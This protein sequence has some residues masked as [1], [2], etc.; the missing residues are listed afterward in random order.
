MDRSTIKT[1]V[2]GLITS[3]KS[4]IQI[5]KHEQR[6]ALFFSRNKMLSIFAQKVNLWK[7]LA[8]AMTILL[9]I[10][11]FMS[12]GGLDDDSRQSNPHFM[13]E[14]YPEFS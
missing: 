10:F 3:A 7:D 2:A 9:N 11:I 4:M 12:Y 14:F 8:F 1:K 5:A 13:L 6:L